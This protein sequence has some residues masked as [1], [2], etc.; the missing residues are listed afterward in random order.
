MVIRIDIDGI[1]VAQVAVPDGSSAPSS[2][3]PVSSNRLGASFAESRALTGGN[4]SIVTGGNPS[5]VTGA[6]KVGGNPSIVTGGN[7]SIVTGG[8]PGSRP[9]LVIGP[10]V[11]NR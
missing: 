5:I 3:N 9:V 10:I 2:S 1:V 11:I 6:Q 4:P 7:P 8:E